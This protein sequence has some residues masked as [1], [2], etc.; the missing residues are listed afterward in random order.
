MP[1]TATFK[2]FTI[3][4]DGHV[5]YD[6]GDVPDVRIETAFEQARA[7]SAAAARWS[8]IVDLML[9]GQRETGGGRV[10]PARR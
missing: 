3:I 9:A 10:V 4:R 1:V 6:T 5:V 8:Q 2:R 7:R